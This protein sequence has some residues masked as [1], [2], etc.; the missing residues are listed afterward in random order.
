M[1]TIRRT[2]EV[3]PFG[4]DAS[5]TFAMLRSGP[6]LKSPDAIQLA[7]AASAGTDLS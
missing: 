1:D 5:E 7:C 3:I 6:K 2:A 4:V